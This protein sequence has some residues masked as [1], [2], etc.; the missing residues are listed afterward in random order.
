MSHS[1]WVTREWTVMTGTVMI[2]MMHFC[3][4]W[5]HS[6]INFFCD[7][8]S[9]PRQC[10]LIG[11][12]PSATPVS[13]NKDDFDNLQN[14][15]L[16][17]CLQEANKLSRLCSVSPLVFRHS[18]V[19]GGLKKD[20]SIG[21]QKYGVEKRKRWRY[22]R[23][24]IQS[25][26]S[27]DFFFSFLIFPWC[28]ASVKMEYSQVSLRWCLRRCSI[29]DDFSSCRFNENF[30]APDGS[31]HYVCLSALMDKRYGLKTQEDISF[32]PKLI[33]PSPLWQP[34]RHI[35]FLSFEKI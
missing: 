12:V 32:F 20:V 2:K 3:S 14:P 26:S 23:C 24:F 21:I 27:L 6:T 19:F 15:K 34:D 22:H 1:Q 16:T 13:L 4:A 30:S 31:C 10:R 7:T 28:S 29:K 5:L 9:A 18:L 17:N 8:P 25:D 35:I 33:L 11:D